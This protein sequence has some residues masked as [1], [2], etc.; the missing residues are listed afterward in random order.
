MS[1]LTTERTTVGRKQYSEGTRERL[2]YCHGAFHA[3]LFNIWAGN[4][5]HS[6]SVSLLVH[7]LFHFSF[8]FETI[9]HDCCTSSSRTSVTTLDGKYVSTFLAFS[10]GFSYLAWYNT[11]AVYVYFS[12]HLARVTLFGSG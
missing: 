7:Y 11:I 9:G 5:Y 12:S 1:F 6:T 4:I 8:H 10:N 3:R 2:G